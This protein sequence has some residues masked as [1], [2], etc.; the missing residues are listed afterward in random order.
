[1]SKIH[2]TEQLK[3]QLLEI[4][5]N[6]VK[7]FTGWVWVNARI[8]NDC[9]IIKE[10][11]L[12]SHPTIELEYDIKTQKEVTGTLKRLGLNK[13][14]LKE[15]KH[16]LYGD[17]EDVN[18]KPTG[19]FVPVGNFDSVNKIA[20]SLTFAKMYLLSRDFVSANKIASS[21]T[22][23][24]VYLLSREKDY[25]EFCSQLSFYNQDDFLRPQEDNIMSDLPNGK[26]IIIYNHGK[27][28][29]STTHTS[30]TDVVFD[31]FEQLAAYY[32]KS[33]G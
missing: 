6:R 5:E 11:N 17:E 23:A 16:V 26:R 12:Y 21:L 20:P 29:L 32:L 30:T 25:K 9:L 15:L 8:K 19:N 22:F 10:K 31:S 18:K 28:V 24:K 7:E 3:E 1:M 33:H 27:F 2:T 4:I 14:L 13:G